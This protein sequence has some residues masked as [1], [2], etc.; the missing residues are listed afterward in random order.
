VLFCCSWLGAVE[1]RAAATGATGA[2]VLFCCSWLGAVEK[3]AAATGATGAREM[4]L[5]WDKEEAR[6]KCMK[7]EIFY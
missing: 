7:G 3:R 4:D 1:K 5:Q 2:R 6:V